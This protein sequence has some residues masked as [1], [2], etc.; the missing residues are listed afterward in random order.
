[1]KFSISTSFYRRAHLVEQI[2]QQILDQTHGDWEWVV[3]DDFSDYGD[4]KELL[5][6]ILFVLHLESVMDSHSD[7]LMDLLLE[8]Q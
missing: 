8:M 4:A 5:L 2:Y 7:S 1:M 6:E 3:T